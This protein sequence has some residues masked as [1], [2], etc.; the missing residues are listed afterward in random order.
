MALATRVRRYDKVIVQFH[1]DVFY[2]HPASWQQRA[3][4]SA[5]LAVAWT[6]AREVE[7]RVHEV[8]YAWGTQRIAG[9][10]T[11]RMFRA[12][13]RIVVHT[14]AEADDFA[15]AFKVPRRRIEVAAHGADFVRR[16][17][18]DRDEARRSLGI[19]AGQ[20]M[21][22]TI[23]FIQPHKGFDRAIRAFAGLD[24]R[25][26]RCRR[27]GPGRGTRLRPSP[28]RTRRTWPPIRP[29]PMC[30]SAS[31]PTTSSTGGWSPVD[32]V[33]LPYRSIWSSGV[34]ERAALYERPVIVT[35]VGGLAAQ[36]E[37]HGDVTVVDDDV[38]LAAAMRARAGVAAPAPVAGPWTAAGTVDRDAVMAEIR[39]R[40]SSSRRVSTALSG[41]PSAKIT[42]ASAPLRRTPP[43]GRPAP[44]SGRPGAGLLKR[45]TRRLIG[46][47]IDPIVHQVNSLRDATIQAIETHASREEER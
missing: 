27:V 47:E 45:L 30:T 35:R 2:P 15:K 44:I 39:A 26:P 11:R 31:S 25:P 21:F 46:W 10:F 8:N 40:A 16:V 17:D 41:P 14:D 5:A 13:D 38:E 37:G 22:L 42:D 1:P 24:G 7:L 4:E 18:C 20:F 36:A 19:P 6:A 33:V 12:A 9:L 34:L 23:G 29:A 28:R 32:V 43:L 3:M